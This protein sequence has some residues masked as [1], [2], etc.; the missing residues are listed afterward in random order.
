[1]F[2]KQSWGSNLHNAA[3]KHSPNGQS[4]NAAKSGKT[5]STAQTASTA[6]SKRE[7]N[8]ASTEQVKQAGAF[9]EGCFDRKHMSLWSF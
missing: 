9:P 2:L 4:N 6:Q 8:A 3:N 7:I 1:V 5:P